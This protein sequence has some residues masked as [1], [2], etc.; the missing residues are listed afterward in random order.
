MKL[1]SNIKQLEACSVIDADTAASAATMVGNEDKKQPALS[2]PRK[3]ADLLLLLKNTS[4]INQIRHS[5]LL[6]AKQLLDADSRLVE[7]LKQSVGYQLDLLHQ[8]KLMQNQSSQ[9]QHQVFVPYLQMLSAQIEQRLEQV[10][11]FLNDQYQSQQAGGLDAQPSQHH[12]KLA[13]AEIL[14][15]QYECVLGLGAKYAASK[16]V[17]NK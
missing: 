3:L 10:K 12:Q 13:I 8:I 16:Q 1:D 4:T 17:L 2:E 14:N 9:N 11:S 5:H 7:A 15:N 6:P